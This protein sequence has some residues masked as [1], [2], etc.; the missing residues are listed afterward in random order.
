MG[1][2]AVASL[3]TA[4]IVVLLVANRRTRLIVGNVLAGAHTM[5]GSVTSTLYEFGSPKFEV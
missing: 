4:T 2:P 3:P 5:E 1:P